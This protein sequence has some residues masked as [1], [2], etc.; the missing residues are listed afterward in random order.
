MSSAKTTPRKETVQTT[1][2]R[3]TAF[4]EP[5]EDSGWVVHVPALPG[6]VTE[7][8]T[9]EEAREMVKDA[10]QGYLECLRKDG[11][12]I[13]VEPPSAMTESV[14]VIVSRA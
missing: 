7:G 5:G 4:F 8:R 3:Y 6:C 10:I 12:D 1:E 13:P 2:Y 9:L 11:E 14:T